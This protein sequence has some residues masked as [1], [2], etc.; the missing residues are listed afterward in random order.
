MV[1]R[2][3][4]SPPCAAQQGAP[5]GLVSCPRGVFA[6][7]RRQ[8]A[9]TL[10]VWPSRRRPRWTGEFTVRSC[11]SRRPARIRAPAGLRASGIRATGA[12][13]QRRLI[14]SWAPPT[15]SGGKPHAHDAVA[16]APSPARSRRH[17]EPTRVQGAQAQG[18]P[19]PEPPCAA[20]P[21]ARPCWTSSRTRA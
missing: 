10:S 17:G 5:V 14:K 7:A 2:F 3:S 4:R 11:P 13:I 9:V 21:W 16:A 15:K 18:S 19:L 1:T 20:S 8:R 12:A 6:P